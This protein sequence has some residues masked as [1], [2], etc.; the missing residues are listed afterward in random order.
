MD[1]KLLLTGHVAQNHTQYNLLSNARVTLCAHGLNLGHEHS[2]RFY[3]RHTCGS[4]VSAQEFI[5]VQYIP[6]RL[7][8][9]DIGRG[10]P[11]KATEPDATV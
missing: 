5:P 10:S 9:L 11:G 3:C 7:S 1:Q 8:E 2:Q 4:Q 6:L